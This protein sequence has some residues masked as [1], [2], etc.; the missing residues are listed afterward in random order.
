MK[1]V[2]FSKFNKPQVLSPEK[3]SLAVTTVKQFS[4]VLQTLTVDR[5]REI[6]RP[7][8]TYKIDKNEVVRWVK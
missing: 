5:D 8:F 3:T 1:Q 2:W 6:Q 4:R 7:V